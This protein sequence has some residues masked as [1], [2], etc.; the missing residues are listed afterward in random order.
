MHGQGTI[1]IPVPSLETICS[2]LWA[3]NGLLLLAEGQC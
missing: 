3:I 2:A 1:R